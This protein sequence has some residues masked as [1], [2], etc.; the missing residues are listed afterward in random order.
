MR[1]PQK[2]TQREINGIIP[3]M[4][5]RG[6]NGLKWAILNHR[7]FIKKI[8]WKDKPIIMRAYHRYFPVDL[9]QEWKKYD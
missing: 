4:K 5:L 7:E 2:L 9:L 1:I 8:C 6:K 3:Q